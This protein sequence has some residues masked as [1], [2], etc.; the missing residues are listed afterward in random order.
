RY[1]VG[2]AG[3]A[4]GGQLAGGGGGGQ[5]AGG[6]GV[7]QVGGGGG[8]GQ[9][10]AGP[11]RGPGDRALAAE[12]VLQQVA[13]HR[14]HVDEHGHRQEFVGQL[15][16]HGPFS[17]TATASRGSS[18]DSPMRSATRANSSAKPG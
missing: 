15:R 12:R 11:G 4:G 16:H 2:G 8:G 18:F 13:H 6:G 7:E 3:G 9:F 1:P 14:G 5:L 17:P 10:P